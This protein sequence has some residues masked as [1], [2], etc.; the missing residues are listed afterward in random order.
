[1]SR[2]RLI[3]LLGVVAIIFA[4]A[5]A[6]AP[7]ALAAGVWWVD[8]TN[9]SLCS[10]AGLGTS[11]APL[12]TIS[13][14]AARATTAGDNVMVRPGTYPEQVTVAASG[15]AGSPITFTASAPGVVVL[16]TRD[17]S[18]VSGWVQVG[19]TPVWSQAYAPPSAPSLQLQVFSDGVRMV[20]A[21]SLALIAPGQFFYTAVTIPATPR[22]LYVDAGGPNPA[23]GHTI[24][25][26]AQAYGFNLVGRS[27]VV[28][29]GFTLKQQNIAGVHLSG[30]SAVTVQNVTATQ[31][32]GNGI[33]AEAA[34]S[35]VRVTGSTVSGSASIGIK[36]SATTGSVI[37][38]NISHDN[39]SHGISL[40]AS[41]N[42]IVS[43]N[44]SYSNVNPPPAV[45][46][47]V[48]IDVS[49]SSTGVTVVQNTTYANRDSG[50]EIYT[51]SSNAIVARNISYDNGDHGLDCLNSPGESVVGNTVVGNV[52]AGINLEGTLAPAC[53][54][55]VVGDNISSDNAVV[56]AGSTTPVGDIRL[57][58]LSTPGSTLD[59][60]VTFMTNGGAL[61]NWNTL[62]YTTVSA[63]R[64]ASAQGSNDI[65]ADPVFT[66]L[67]AR[68]LSLQISSP[69]VDS[70]DLSMRSAMAADHDGHSPVDQP[71]V[72]NTGAGTPSFADRGALELG[73]LAATAP[74]A[75]T[76]VQATAGNA[77]AV[78]SWTARASDGGSAVTGYTVTAAPGGATASTSG[79]TTATV[80]GLTNG[81]SYTFSVTATNAVAT[82]PASAAS[83]AVTPTAAM[84]GF[85]GRAPTRVLDTRIG[86][87]APVAKLGAGATLTLAVPG[88]P[89]GATAVAIN[90]TV[91]NPTAGS[92]LSVYPGGTTRPTASNLNFVAGQTI[93]NLVVVPLGSGGTVTFYNAV[94]TVNVIADLVGSFAPGTGAGFTGKAPTRVLDT[95]IGTGAAKAKL[96]A[97]ATLTLTV[98]GL[99]A[100]ATAVAMNVTANAPTAGSYLSVYP[101]HGSRPTASNLNFAARE[102]IPNMVL[103]PLGPGG[104]VTFYN[105]VGTVSVIA[106]LVGYFAPGSG[107]GFSGTAPTRVLDTRI[108][109]GAPVAK[110]GAGGTLT[111]TVPGLPAGAT[112][113]AM[114]VTVANPTAGSYLSVYPGGTPRPT[115]SNLNFVTGQAIPNLVVVPLGPGGTVTFYNAVG[116]VNVIADLV[117]YFK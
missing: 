54:G 57:D 72:P 46:S 74:A 99:P 113:V 86:T 87:G 22:V 89:A 108:G 32:G 31:S 66:N 50:I 70:A 7:V 96:G 9:P 60:N 16:G 52:T 78:V 73:G 53:S 117:G 49:A 82:S 41:S 115:A 98:P 76:G 29:D 61:Y 84:A 43:G 26:F 19:V 39:L 12:C 48:G 21:A 1:M 81:T 10:D 18:V 103:V 65:G 35:S 95:R 88:L 64:A 109:T 24:A 79:A 28:V 104:T 4:M 5:T 14:A 3:S 67:A 40:Q 116:T 59:R 62:A 27:N 11:A 93:P 42:N 97:G 94:G 44:T 37:S 20:P 6:Q 85:T 100:G 91:A 80:A 111:L 71:G 36:L 51:G 47:A 114:N 2:S 92:Y 34:S 68:D 33:L 45:H 17:L 58:T 105:A 107:A 63:F 106:D 55:S 56:T 8:N 25:A 83:A 101:G 23:L 112:A 102:T 30:S 77:Q 13:A 38:G 75:P 15:T 69:A 90:V 110:L